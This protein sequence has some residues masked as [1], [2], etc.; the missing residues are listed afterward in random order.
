MTVFSAL[1]SDFQHSG[2]LVHTS[3]DVDTG[4]SALLRRF[5][6]E[7][8]NKYETLKLFIYCNNYG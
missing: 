4:F 8:H 2:Y 1:K 3:Y 5:N 6:R 7:I